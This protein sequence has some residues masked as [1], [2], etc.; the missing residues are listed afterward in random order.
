MIFLIGVKEHL[1]FALLLPKKAIQLNVQENAGVLFPPL[2]L[3]AKVDIALLDYQVCSGRYLGSMTGPFH[4]TVEVKLSVILGKLAYNAHWS[5]YVNRIQTAFNLLGKAAIPSGFGPC[6]HN[7]IRPLERRC[8][9]NKVETV[10][11]K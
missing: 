8:H 2:F 5:S 9:C 6:P 7:A 10:Q 1:L 3:E 4:G 11:W